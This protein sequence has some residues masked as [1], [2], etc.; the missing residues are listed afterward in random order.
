MVQDTVDIDNHRTQTPLDETETA[1][2]RGRFLFLG[3]FL[4]IAWD[5]ADAG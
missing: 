1:F 4:L 2:N 5:G 3:A